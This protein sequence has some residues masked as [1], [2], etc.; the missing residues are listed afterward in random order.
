M[1]LQ[2]TIFGSEC[3]IVAIGVDFISKGE[4]IA[5]VKVSCGYLVHCKIKKLLKLLLLHNVITAPPGHTPVSHR[6]AMIC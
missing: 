1:D 3:W 6:L 2:S 4:L 5:L